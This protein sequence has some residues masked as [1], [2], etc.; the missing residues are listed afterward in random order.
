MR[1]D[2]IFKDLSTL[3]DVLNLCNKNEKTRERAR[4]INLRIFCI[5]EI[6]NLA[7]PHF[8]FTRGPVKHNYHLHILIYHLWFL[9]FPV[10][11]VKSFNKKK[12]GILPPYQCS[13]LPPRNASLIPNYGSGSILY[14]SVL[15]IMTF[16]CG[17]GSADPCLWL[18]D[19]DADPDPAIFIIDLQ[20]AK[21]K[22][23]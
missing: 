20:D 14:R 13:N 5:E 21:R 3:R 2:V 23:I 10:L 8:S 15:G 12:S 9:S 17:F 19:P 7:Y 18:M 22:L 4:L 6:R 16:W 11:P 1:L